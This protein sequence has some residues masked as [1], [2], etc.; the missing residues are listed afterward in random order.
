[1]LSDN[2]SASNGNGESLRFLDRVRDCID[3]GPSTLGQG[4]LQS[5]MRISEMNPR[6]LSKLTCPLVHPERRSLQ[7]PPGQRP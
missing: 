1:M 5:A 4:S 6:P 2:H 3:I 7:A